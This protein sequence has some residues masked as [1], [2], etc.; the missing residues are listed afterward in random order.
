MVPGYSEL[1]INFSHVLWRRAFE[2]ERNAPDLLPFC[3]F[4]GESLSSIETA[5]MWT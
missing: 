5:A 4:E 2:M 1:Q 3:L